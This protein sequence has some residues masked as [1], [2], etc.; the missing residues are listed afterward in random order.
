MFLIN[1][2]KAEFITAII[3]RNKNNNLEAILKELKLKIDE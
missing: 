2:F 3:E 1:T